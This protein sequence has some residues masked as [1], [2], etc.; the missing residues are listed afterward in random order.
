MS[1][2][3]AR[4][5]YLHAL[6]PLVAAL[7]IAACSNSTPP[8]IGGGAVGSGTAVTSDATIGRNPLTDAPDPT[9][10]ARQIIQNPTLA[11][12][13]TPGPDLP[14]MYLGKAEAPVTIVQYASLTCPHCRAFHRDVFPQ[15]KREYIDTGKVRYILREFPI[16]KTSGT[17]TIALRCAAPGKYFELY[18]KFLEQQ[19]SWVSQEVRL[20]PIFAV[21][22]QVGVT[23]PEFDQCL[24]NQAM[25]DGLKRVKDRGRTL[26][27]IGTPNFFV[28][29]QRVKSTLTMAE[30]RNMVDPLLSGRTAA[31]ANAAPAR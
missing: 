26:G 12:V 15:F 6:V 31:T 1:R 20:D 30:I 5:T 14:E 27:I 21:A 9:A 17:A 7:F 13:I 4:G 25:I 11:E 29:N 8:A 28:Q 19:P 10:G 24:Q 16:G 2:R 23:R 3:T 18:G 22:Q